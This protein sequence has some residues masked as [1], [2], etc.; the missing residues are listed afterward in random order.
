MAAIGKQVAKGTVILSSAQYLAMFVNIL[1]TLY[2]AAILQPINYG[3][4]GLSLTTVNL[5]SIFAQS[6]IQGPTIK[7]LSANFAKKDY[8]G[9]R[10]NIGI[11]MG[12][13]VIM[14]FLVF[15]VFYVIAPLLANYLYR[16]PEMELYLHMLSV[17]IILGTTNAVNNAILISKRDYISLS[18]LNFANTLFSALYPILLFFLTG[19]SVFSLVLAYIMGQF[20]YT[21]IGVF[22]ARGH[23]KEYG[24][25]WK[26]IF[27]L[28]Q[29]WLFLRKGF[30]FEI[31]SIAY[32]IFN[33]IDIIFLGIFASKYELGL[34]SF[35]KGLIN[36]IN[37]SFSS[38]GVLF[39][40]AISELD[41]KDEKV[42]IKMAA[43]S[44][45]IL[46]FV[47][48]F[49]ALFLFFGSY[50]MILLLTLFI[51]SLVDYLPSAYILAIM[52]LGFLTR[53]YGTPMSSYFFG[54]G[55]FDI[56][57][58]VSSIQCIFAIIAYYVL[59]TFYGVLGIAIGTAI[60]Y[61]IPFFVFS[62]YA[63][64]EGLPQPY[65]YTVMFVLSGM[66]VGFFVK[67]IVQ[68]LQINTILSI[69]VQFSG[70]TLIY[71][72]A[73]LVAHGITID[74]IRLLKRHIKRKAVLRFLNIAEKII[75][76]FKSKEK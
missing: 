35:A 25:N 58:K 55:N 68:Y 26:P 51:E 7:Y 70:I 11:T 14:S 34:Y 63:L 36:K 61:N 74:D 33:R 16:Q 38:F 21:A 52:G 6:P 62:Y 24:I 32:A 72:I 23:L 18:I 40:P 9:I 28:S 17:V 15:T 67:M 30:F 75:I 8:E 37:I 64:R 2:I 50:E 60:A 20:T 29:I 44:A 69:I 39:Y 4:Y 31:N 47:S 59:G 49:I 27:D 76:L 46:S 42:T 53:G 65:F 5:I 12:T 19:W 43:I 41:E 56:P 45:K 48:T 54:K 73:I 1:I 71:P 13:Y 57:A 22:F 10:A 66:V 3:I